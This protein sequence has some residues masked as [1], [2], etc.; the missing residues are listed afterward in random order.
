MKP[1]ARVKK[2]I[3]KLHEDGMPY[4]TRYGTVQVVIDSFAEVR[5][6]DGSVTFDWMHLLHPADRDLGH[7]EPIGYQDPVH[8]SRPDFARPGR[9][10]ATKE[11]YDRK[12][13]QLAEELSI[14]PF[15]P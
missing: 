10:S 9:W 7:P 11:E 15:G 3:C 5:W 13:A 2:A 6:D 12:V 8:P 14:R 1:T 4:V